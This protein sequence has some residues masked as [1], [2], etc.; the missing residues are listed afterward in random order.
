MKRWTFSTVLLSTLLLGTCWAQASGVITSPL[1][2]RMAQAEADELIRIYITMERHA[3]LTEIEA[4]AKGLDKDG[5]RQLVLARLST[6]AEKD[7]AAVLRFLESAQ[8]DGKVKRIRS[9]RL[10]NA[11]CCEA[12]KEIIQRLIAVEGINYINWDKRMKV[13]HET[14]DR[15]HRAK[16]LLRQVTRTATRGAQ[17]LPSMS[18]ETNEKG[19]QAGSKEIPWGIV[20]INAD[21]VWALGYTGDGVIVGHLDTGVNYNHLDLRDHMWDG[22][23]FGVPNHGRDLV[24]DDWDPMDDEGHG[25]HTAGTIASDGTAGSQVGVAPDAQIM[26]FKVWDDGGYGTQGDAWDALDYCGYWGAD[27]VSMSGG[28]PHDYPLTDLCQWRL[29]CD[30]LMAAGVVFSTSAGNGDNLGGHYAVPND[31]STPADVPAPWYPQPNPGDEHHSSI[32][33]VGATNSVDNIASFS[34]YGPTEWSV[35]GCGSHDY[36]DYNYPPGLLKPEVCA[37]GVYIKSLDYAD[38]AGYAGPAGWSGTSMSCPHVTGTLALMLEKNPYLTPVQMDSILEATAVELGPSGRDSLY[39]AGRIDALAAVNAT[40]EVGDPPEAIADLSSTLT[41]G[42]AKS[43]SGDI[44]LSWTEPSSDLGVDYYVIY[45]ATD[46]DGPMDS[47]D[48]TP[49]TSYTDSGAAGDTLTNYFYTVK[50]VD[51]GGQKASDS[52]EAGEFDIRLITVVKSSPS[53]SRTQKFK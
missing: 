6:F 2:D 23:G 10:G 49:D 19:V 33:A 3:D 15:A 48:S 39:G 16:Q 42:I 52:N 1:A 26:I 25:T 20:K 34:S 18:I 45:R 38:T 8:A 22:S 4:A 11:V 14:G 37:P 29:E 27:L 32:I 53:T 17:R 31:I 13:L 7:Q 40:P 24:N 44:H 36:D 46:P 47:L 43:S 5:R 41:N 21:D 30:A 9:L 50:A 28:W 51:Q 35:T 12:T